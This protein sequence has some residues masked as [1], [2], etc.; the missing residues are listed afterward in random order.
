MI[1]P[2]GFTPALRPGEPYACPSTLAPAFITIRDESCWRRTLAAANRSLARAAASHVERRCP[3]LLLR[4]QRRPHRGRLDA[5]GR[6]SRAAPATTPS[7]GLTLGRSN[8][9]VRGGRLR[10]RH[11]PGRTAVRRSR[12]SATAPATG[13]SPWTSTRSPTLSASS[14]PWLRRRRPGRLARC[15]PSTLSWTAGSECSHH[16][17][18]AARRTRQRR[19]IDSSSGCLAGSTA[20]SPPTLTGTVE[21]RQHPRRAALLCGSRSSPRV[22]QADRPGD[23][24]RGLAGRLAAAALRME[25]GVPQ[26]EIAVAEHYEAVRVG[27]GSTPSRSGLTSSAGR[28]GYRTKPVR[29]AARR[30]AERGA[31]WQTA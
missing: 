20:W 3:L 1:G 14:A 31:K 4:R 27:S 22:V 8:V 16:R 26:L 24:H 5:A 30:A 15:P 6:A 18:R 29:S 19:G 21:L 10:H 25:Y 7:D 12:L 28:A 17:Q 9:S 11:L 2:D 13:A 23:R